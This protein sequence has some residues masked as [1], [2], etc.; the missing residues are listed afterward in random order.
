[1]DVKGRGS[2]KRGSVPGAGNAY[3]QEM[4]SAVAANAAAPASVAQRVK[5]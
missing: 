2:E 5:S 4:A 3:A 1:M